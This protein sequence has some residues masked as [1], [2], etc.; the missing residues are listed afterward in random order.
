MAEPVDVARFYAQYLNGRGL[1]VKR[2]DRKM[3]EGVVSMLEG[4][5]RRLRVRIS[6][7]RDSDEGATSVLLTWRKS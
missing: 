3:G 5:K 7:S 4:R 2:R 6:A 1:R